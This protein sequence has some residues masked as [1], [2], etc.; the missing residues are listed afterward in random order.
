MKA[1][2]LLCSR[3]AQELVYLAGWSFWSVWF[4]RM[5]FQSDRQNKPDRRDKPNEPDL[6]GRAQRKI[7]PPPSLRG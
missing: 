2:D 6:V 1:D 3:N 5:N 7:N 4:F